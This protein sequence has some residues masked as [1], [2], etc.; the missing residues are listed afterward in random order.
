MV[1]GWGFAAAA[2]LWR[3]LKV[4]DAD[5]YASFNGL[6]HMQSSHGGIGSFS[7]YRHSWLVGHR[8]A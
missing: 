6:D 3:G 4:A 2:V 8:L 5:D 1:I 7:D